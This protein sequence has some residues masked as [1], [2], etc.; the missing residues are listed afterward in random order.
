MQEWH[1]TCHTHSIN[2]LIAMYTVH[3]QILCTKFL[4]LTHHCWNALLE[5]L[6]YHKVQRYKNFEDYHSVCV[7][8]YI[9][10]CV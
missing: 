2:F 4:K 9:Y 7:Y 10:V 6:E 1:K 3:H 5:S 8:K